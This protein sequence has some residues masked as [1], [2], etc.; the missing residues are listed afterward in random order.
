MKTSVR[1]RS[2]TVTMGIDFNV[3]KVGPGDSFGG[4]SLLTGM[5]SSE[6]LTAATLGLLLELHSENLKPILQSRPELVESLCDSAARLQQFVATFYRAAIQPVV[7]EHHDLL[8]R[9]KNFFHLAVLVTR[10]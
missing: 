7:I 3:R 1:N 6:T 10:K 9:I 2:K 8:S 4:I 5:P